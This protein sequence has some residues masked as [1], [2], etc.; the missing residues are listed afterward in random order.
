MSADE[1]PPRSAFE[2]PAHAYCWSEAGLGYADHVEANS[3]VEALRV[4][5]GH[6]ECFAT[7]IFRARRSIFNESPF[8]AGGHLIWFDEQPVE[9]VDRTVCRNDDREA[10]RP[11]SDVDRD[12]H[13]SLLDEVL[14]QLD[15]VGVA[16]EPLAIG[17]PHIG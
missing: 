12:A 11:A 3:F 16:S 8:D 10:E 1:C 6:P 7:L 13:P 9:L 2:I 17:L 14:R 4:T 15:R 5:S